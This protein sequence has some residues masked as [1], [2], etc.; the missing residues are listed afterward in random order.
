[1]RKI[2]KCLVTMLLMTTLFVGGVPEV[3]G[4]ETINEEVGLFYVNT[5]S[6]KANLAISS[7][8][9]TC[10][11]TNTMTKNYT[12]KIT[13][14]LQKSSNNS[15]YSKVQSWSKSYT[16]IGSKTITKTQALTKGYYY[17]VKVVV[18]V[19][20]GDEVIE[21]ITKYSTVVKY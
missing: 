9:A 15:T 6:V 17:R 5:S 10:K 19:Y 13:M 18:R 21:K 3:R 20:S 7:G 8:I 16:G 12:S 11:A 1:M 4:S 2:T 14:T